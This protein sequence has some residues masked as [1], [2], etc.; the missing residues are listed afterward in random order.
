MESSVASSHQM[1]VMSVMDLIFSLSSIPLNNHTEP[2][3]KV[4]VYVERLT[5]QCEYKPHLR[6][7]SVAN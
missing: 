4:I 6:S 7:K 1:S 2:F 5:R 3:G